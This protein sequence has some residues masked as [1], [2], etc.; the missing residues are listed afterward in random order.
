M[1]KKSTI[2][3][4]FITKYFLIISCNHPEGSF[5]IFFIRFL[6]IIREQYL[7]VLCFRKTH[8]I[9]VIIRSVLLIYFFY[10]YLA[11]A[12]VQSNL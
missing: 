9:I 7:I 2:T 6:N 11:N 5:Y 3:Y 1:W 12:F 4:L 8:G 10:V